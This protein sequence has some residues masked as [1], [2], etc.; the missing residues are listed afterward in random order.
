MSTLAAMITSLGD[1]F[2]WPL[3]DGSW[4]GKIVVQGLILIIPIVGQIAALGWLLLCMDNLRDGRDELPP[5]G[6]HLERGIGLFGVYL[7]YIGVPTIVLIV[8]SSIGSAL[9]ANDV[10]VGGLLVT[11]ILLLD[12]VISLLLVFVAPAAASTTWERGFSAGMDVAAVWRRA[13]ANV[14]NSILTALLIVAAVII[15]SFGV[16]LC[17]VGALF[18]QIWAYAVAAAALFWFARQS[19]GIQTPSPERPIGPPPPPPP[20]Y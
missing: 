6:F 4:L 16:I 9:L 2:G 3:K 12:I 19:A 14:T 18:T 8:I 15:A 13:T 20:S 7:L 11:W 17:F 10:G 1:S 5:A